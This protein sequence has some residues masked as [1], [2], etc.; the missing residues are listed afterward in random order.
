MHASLNDS[1]LNLIDRLHV[2]V[3][4][5]YKDCIADLRSDI[6]DPQFTRTS[7]LDPNLQGDDSAP[8]YRKLW[9]CLHCPVHLH[10]S[11]DRNEVIA[12]VKSASVSPL[13]FPYP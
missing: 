12:H 5:Y 3:L 8:T 4:H 10:S 11:V 2:Q 13:C 6:I 1:I 9:S 7:L